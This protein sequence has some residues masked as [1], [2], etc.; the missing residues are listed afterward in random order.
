[1]H[2]KDCIAGCAVPLSMAVS[3]K[4]SPDASCCVLAVE[5]CTHDGH[6]LPV[7]VTV[8]AG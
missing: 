2:E 5:D 8:P 6:F 1:M 7:A 3:D 4:L